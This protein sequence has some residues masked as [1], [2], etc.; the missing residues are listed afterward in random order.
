[1]SLATV[2][3]LSRLFDVTPS[4]IRQLTTDGILTADAEGRYEIPSVITEYVKYLHKSLKE[5]GASNSKSANLEQRRLEADLRLKTAKAKQE[6]MKL[7]ALGEELKQNPKGAEVTEKGTVEGLGKRASLHDIATFIGITCQGLAKVM[8]AYKDA[9]DKSEDRKYDSRAMLEWYY[10]KKTLRNV[11]RTLKEEAIA[12]DIRAKRIKADI[13]EGRVI[14]LEVA[15]NLVNSIYQTCWRVLVSNAKKYGTYAQNAEE[16][17]R[18][19]FAECRRQL[20]ELTEAD[21]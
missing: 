11:P 15:F 21:I 20:L 10:G 1:M 3:N 16:G 2:E 8:G 13:L 6:E 9:P 4:K 12:E 18:N 19:D 17:A 5:A 7:E 14:K